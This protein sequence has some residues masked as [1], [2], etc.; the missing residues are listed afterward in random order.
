MATPAGFEPATF[1]LEIT[2]SIYLNI[3]SI[4]FIINYLLN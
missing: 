1:G 3:V 4:F 2:Y